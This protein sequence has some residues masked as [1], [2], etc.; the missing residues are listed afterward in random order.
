MTPSHLNHC[1]LSLVP[2]PARGEPSASIAC[3]TPRAPHPGSGTTARAV[4]AAPSSVSPG[5]AQPDPAGSLPW[6]PCQGHCQAPAVTQFPCWNGWPARQG[7][8][9]GVN[10]LTGATALVSPHLVL[11]CWHGD[12]AHGVGRSPAPQSPGWMGILLPSPRAG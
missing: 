12:V 8:G 5:L 1:L 9:H 2:H 4:T 11:R 7:V 6:A 3:P 10:P